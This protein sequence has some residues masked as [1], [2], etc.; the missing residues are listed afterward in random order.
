MGS[1]STAGLPSWAGDFDCTSWAQF[2]LKYVLAN[3]AVT[4]VLT[5]TTSVEH[6]AENI[7]TAFGR[8]PDQATRLRMRELVQGF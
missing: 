5:E 4:C 3:P 1:R 2:S 7:G 8:L 6:M